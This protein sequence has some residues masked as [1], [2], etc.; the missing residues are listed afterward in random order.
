MSDQI[1]PLELDTKS[2]ETTDAKVLETGGKVATLSNLSGKDSES[3]LSK[4]Q[5]IGLWFA[6]VFALLFFLYFFLFSLDLMGSSFKVVGGCSAGAM[7]DGIN[8]PIAGLMIGILATVLVQ[9]SSTSTSIV[10]SLVGADAMSVEVAIPVIMGANIGTSITNTIVSFGQVVDPDQF[11]RAFAGATVHDMFNFLNVSVLLI[12]EL[13]FHPLYYMTEAMIGGITVTDDDSWEG[14]IKKLVS[15]L[16]KRVLNP[17]KDVIKYIATGE[18]TCESF[19]EESTS[20]ATE[21]HYGL[22]K[23]DSDLGCPLFYSE[24]NTHDDDLVAG[25]VCLFLS[26]LFLIIC[27]SGLVTVLKSMVLNTSE[28]YIKKA[29][30]IKPFYAMCVGAGVTILVQSSS[31]TT[32]VLTPLVGLKVITVE[33]MYPLT[34]GANVGTT[35]TALLASL[36]SDKVE[37][38]QIALCHLFFNIFGILIFFPIPYMRKLPVRAAKTLGSLT[39]RWK[40]TPIL[41][42]LFAFVI[43]PAILLG[44]SSLYARGN[45]GF[46]VLGVLVTVALLSWGVYMAHYWYRRNGKAEFYQWADK[47]QEKNEIFQKEIPEQWR[48]LITEVKELRKQVNELTGVTVSPSDPS[49]PS[50]AA[51]PSKVAEP[52]AAPSKE[53]EPQAVPS[54]EAEPQ[55]ES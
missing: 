4:N 15:P 38:V 31:I 47:R 21:V 16:V 50:L 9:S 41:Y 32:S 44:V 54:K 5:I 40:A 42:I 36:V 20:N 48:D 22:I 13:I 7:F 3:G 52:Q 45:A 19:Y 23:C 26:L 17:N 28:E 10:V 53:A 46:T 55:A 8:N 43:V 33:Q 30:D 14:P 18:A 24:D 25:G 2:A 51:A 27:L 11:E 39:R 37:A 6:R 29:T 49:P 1:A 34:L 35:C 12:I